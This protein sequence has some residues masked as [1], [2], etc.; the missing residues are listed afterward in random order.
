MG[1]GRS[2]SRQSDSFQAAASG[3]DDKKLSWKTIAALTAVI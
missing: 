1:G 2:K 3:P